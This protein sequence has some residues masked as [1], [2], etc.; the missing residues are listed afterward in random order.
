MDF[1]HDDYIS[2]DKWNCRWS[3][4][5][6]YDDD[7]EFI[8]TKNYHA[9]SDYEADSDNHADSDYEADSDYHAD[10]DNAEYYY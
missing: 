5:A 3:I 6:F 8:I 2:C 9:D 7:N 10:S 1:N 4:S